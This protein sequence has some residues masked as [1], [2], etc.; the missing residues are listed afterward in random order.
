VSV[1]DKLFN[2]V[3]FT[4]N[5]RSLLSTRIIFFANFSW[6]E[7]SANVDITITTSF[8]WFKIH[9]NLC[10]FKSLRVI[11]DFIFVFMIKQITRREVYKIPTI[12]RDDILV[13][14][15]RLN[16][17]YFTVLCIKTNKSIANPCITVINLIDS[18]KMTLQIPLRSNRYVIRKN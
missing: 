3:S 7:L 17:R 14:Y 8:G 13:I 18:V 12:L 15:D 11:I 1:G 2:L 10:L 9:V 5:L 16:R 4:N 6:R